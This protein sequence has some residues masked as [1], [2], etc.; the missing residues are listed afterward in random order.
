MA[1]QVKAPATKPDDTSCSWDPHG[2]RKKLISLL[3][4]DFQTHHGTHVSTCVYTYTHQKK[5]NPKLIIFCFMIGALH[6]QA[7]KGTV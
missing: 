5:K 2:G 1:E 4:S 3:S 6:H 7:N